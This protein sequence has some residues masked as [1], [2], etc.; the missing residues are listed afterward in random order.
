MEHIPRESWLS[1]MAGRTKWTRPM[2]QWL[3]HLG[4]RGATPQQMLWRLQDIF[5]EPLYVGEV[6]AEYA[7]LRT[8]MYAFYFSRR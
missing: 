2:L 1:S 7:H 3:I 6:V 8:G 4:Q 5:G